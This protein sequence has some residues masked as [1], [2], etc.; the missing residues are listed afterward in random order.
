MRFTRLEGSNFAGGAFWFDDTQGGEASRGQIYRLIPG[1]ENVAGADTL[2]LFFESTDL[3]VLD[4]PDNIIVTPWGDIWCAEDG[5][6]ENRVIGITPEGGTYVFGPE[7]PPRHERVRGTDVL[8]GRPDVLRERAGSRDDL[9]DLG[10]VRPPE[11]RPAAYHGVRGPPATHHRRVRR[12]GGGS[13]RYGL[14]RLEA[15]AYSR[16]GV[17]LA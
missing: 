15:A 10:P 8:T 11:P 2:E 1:P 17:P 9:R 7:R 16:L 14:T 4:L 12:A 5:G 6:G 13:R 3:N